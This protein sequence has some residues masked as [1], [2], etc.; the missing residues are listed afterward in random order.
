MEI[1]IELNGE[2]HRAPEGQSLDELVKSLDLRPGRVAVEIN[3]V[4]VPKSDYQHTVLAQGDKVEIIHFVG[5][6]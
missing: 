2:P 4:V 5:G 3:Q 1:T 6:G